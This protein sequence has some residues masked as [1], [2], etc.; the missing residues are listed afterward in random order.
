MTTIPLRDY[1]SGIEELV[2][3][4]QI[5]DALA[6]CRQI[7]KSY[8]KHVD[9]YRM[10][11]KAYLEAQRHSEA[12]DIFQ[13]V[14]SSSP[15]DFVAHIGMSIIREESDDQ[16]G[17]IWNMER[18]F[19]AQPSNR[20]VQ[21]E[22][23]RL[24][25]KREGYAPPK[26]RLT[27]GALARMYAHGGLYNQ[28][29]TE[30]RGALA[31]DPQR[32]DLQVLLTEMYYKT[33]RQAE[34]IEVCSTLIEKLPYCLYANQVMAEILKSNVREVEA[35]PYL[36]RVEELDPYVSQVN[37]MTP[38]AS[39][40]A[41]SVTVE[42]LDLVSSSAAQLLPKAW[43]G[44]L[45]ASDLAAPGKEELPDWLS[46]EEDVEA[47]ATAEEESSVATE[48]IAEKE[49]GPSVLGSLE[50]LDPAPPKEEIPAEEPAPVPP[51]SK[52]PT[53]ALSDDQVPDWLRELGPATGTLSSD[54]I[55]E[56]SGT[57]RTTDELKEIEDPAA[58]VAAEPAP[59]APELEISA[60][61]PAMDD[62]SLGWLERLA[63]DQGAAEEELLTTPE[64]REQANPD[65]AP[66]EEPPK[67][68]SGTLAWLDEMEAEAEKGTKPQADGVQDPTEEPETFSAPIEDRTTPTWLRD[69][70]QAAEGGEQEAENLEPRPL[71][72]AP[73][74]LDE[75][76]PESEP[77]GSEKATDEAT[78]EPPEEWQSS[79]DLSKLD[80]LDDLGKPGG[81]PAES[82]WVPEAELRGSP[83]APEPMAEAA[84]AAAVAE[85]TEAPFAS[86]RRTARL[87]AEENADSWL[88]QARQALNF[89][90]L[91][92]AADHYGKLLRRRLLLDEVIADL[93][94]AVHRSPADATLWQTLGDAYMRNNQLREA[95]DCYTKAEDLL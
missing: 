93:D 29:I 25:G 11:G 48:G 58:E 52:I 64:E 57:N 15:D 28:A 36:E 77:T 37:S 21:D 71:E 19:E 13:R 66:P 88:E 14:L 9:T 38:A 18:A 1:L 56:E 65:W 3:A 81:Q 87:Q 79:A 34:A 78:P 70:S 35:Q 42:Q 22:L 73:D 47:P 83:G 94:A 92:D 55:E 5:D 85:A 7:L 44:A 30:L 51:F 54:D 82:A 8:P 27:R 95:L 39:V 62:D 74:W 17:A 6:H 33:N 60:S 76:R 2:D 80:W 23:R 63:A 10:M 61:E 26:V 41:D 59:E 24:Y 91:D 67:E 45:Q 4:G 75:L 86:P 53:S 12:G 89:G 72:D 84:E 16:D 20:A 69:L 49:T 31:E 40:P 43:T 46:F 32:P 50:S 90:K 68:K